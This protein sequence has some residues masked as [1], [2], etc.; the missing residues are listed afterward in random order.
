MQ[1]RH[2]NRRQYFNE[3]A[4]TTR[5]Y[6]IPF[7]EGVKSINQGDR[8]LEVGCG[9]GGN[10]LPFIER[11]GN[12][13]GV[14]LNERQLDRARQYLAEEG[15]PDIQIIHQNIY[16]SSVDQLGQYDV[17]FLRDVIEHIPD[18]ERFM[19]YIKSFLKPDGVM[20][21][22]FPPWQMPFGGH[23]QV[24]KGW[25]SKIPYVHLL[26]EF[27]Y[28]RIMRLSGIPERIIDS[29]ITIRETGISIERF[30]RCVESAEFSIIRKTHYLTN[31]NYK[32]K[33]GL[34]VKKVIFPFN[35]VSWLRNFYVTCGYYVISNSQ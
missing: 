30:E 22:G 20:F 35:K 9:E 19:K 7:I 23:Q 12:V 11:G 8:I 17:I 28:R 21:F 6:V 34:P 14:D 10:L 26:P 2:Q 3:Q 24:L 13:T 16:D 1:S 5:S 29:R 4:T 15:Y 33:F 32:T 25:V 27:L 18:Q 31:P